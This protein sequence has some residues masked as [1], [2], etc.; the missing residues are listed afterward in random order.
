MVPNGYYHLKTHFRS[1]TFRVAKKEEK[2]RYRIFLK[3][4]C[5]S[6]SILFKTKVK[7]RMH[8]LIAKFTCN[9][10]K[11]RYVQRSKFNFKI[12]RTPFV[13]EFCKQLFYYGFAKAKS[14]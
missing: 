8:T 11:L 10:T 7:F 3:T 9:V 14:D 5:K 2:S 12:I 6:C 1:N 4:E 13:V